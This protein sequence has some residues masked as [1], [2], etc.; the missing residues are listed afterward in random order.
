M[1]QREVEWVGSSRDDLRAF[2]EEVR[3]AIG[4]ALHVAQLGGHHPSAKP[5]VGYRGA[6]VLE[7]VED[8]DGDTYRAVYTLRFADV[9]YVLHAFKKKS[10]HGIATPREDARL[11]ERRLKDAERMH[12][13]RTRR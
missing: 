9:I 1:K 4:H 8:F 2:P 3:V 5:L 6:G 13:E 10:R 11:I 12:A 7:L